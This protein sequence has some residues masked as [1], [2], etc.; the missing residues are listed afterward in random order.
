MR[1]V[2]LLVAVQILLA[3]ANIVLLVR[4]SRWL[5]RLKLLEQSLSKRLEWRSDPTAGFRDPTR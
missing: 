4:T 5:Q 2:P 3:F 1:L